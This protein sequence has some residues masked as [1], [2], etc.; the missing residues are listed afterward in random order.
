M[1]TKPR[2]IKVLIAGLCAVFFPVIQAPTAQAV[3]CASYSIGYQ[4]PLTGP[5]AAFGNSQLNAVKF[6]LTKFKAANSNSMLSS[7]V[8][9]ADDQGDPALSQNAANSL[10]NNSC[11]IAVVGP[12]YSGAS[13]IALPLYL[14][15]GMPVIT[16]SAINETIAQY[17]GNIFHRSARLDKEV[18]LDIMRDVAAATPGATI[19][20]F[21]DKQGYY[22][23]WMTSGFAGITVQNNVLISGQRVDNANAIKDAFDAGARYFLYDGMRNRQDVQDFAADV[24]ALSSANKIIFANDVDPVEIK[25]FYTTALNGSWFYPTSL[26]FSTINPTLGSEFATAYP[27]QLK[28]YVTEAFDAA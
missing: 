10:I 11:V 22:Y 15:A 25:D 5:E 1:I 21:Y 28:T 26:T 12:A 2:L 19:A 20:Y 27:G 4:G 17:G 3:A 6:A 13:R 9:T 24:K 16:P 7:T 18:N 14:A 8:V 23:N